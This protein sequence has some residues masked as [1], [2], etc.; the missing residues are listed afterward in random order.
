MFGLAQQAQQP[1]VQTVAAGPLRR[2]QPTHLWAFLVEVLVVQVVLGTVLGTEETVV[3]GVTPV[4]VRLT[5]ALPETGTRRVQRA[6]LVEPLGLETW[7][8]YCFCN[9]KVGVLA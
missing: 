6:E 1:L 3:V 8:A 9:L 4:W 2:R 7:A 5:L